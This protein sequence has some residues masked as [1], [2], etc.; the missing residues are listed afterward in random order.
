MTAM[1][2]PMMIASTVMTVMGGIEQA[3]AMREAAAANARNAAAVA[4]ANK[5]NADYE[6]GQ[7]QAAAQHT[8]EQDRRKAALMLSRAQALSAASGGGPL[9]ETLAAGL[10]EQGEKQAG[11]SMYT[12]NARAASLR[13]KGDMGVYQ[14]N[15]QGIADINSA[16]SRA[17]AT[18][19]GS[20][21]SAGMSM[22]GRFAP[23]GG[24]GGTSMGGY[25]WMSSRY[26]VS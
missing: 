12:G 4:A 15:A 1:A 24:T 2:V 10:L 6:A 13:Y 14:A 21:A 18:I 23:G 26:S 17:D 22:A 16:N 8:A 20:L 7:E 3:D 9:D 11:Y 5:V 19:L 25:D